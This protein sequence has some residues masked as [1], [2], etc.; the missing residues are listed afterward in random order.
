LVKD[1]QLTNECSPVMN[2]DSQVMIEHSRL[3][4]ENSQGFMADFR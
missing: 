2:E 1:S 4:G 3:T